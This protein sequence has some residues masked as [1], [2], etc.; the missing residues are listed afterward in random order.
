MARSHKIRWKK[1]DYITLG[2]AVANFNKHINEIK[3]LENELYLPDKIDY[4]SLKKDILTRSELKRKIKS[5]K[6]FQKETAKDLYQ[7]EAGEIMTQWE[8]QQLRNLSRV[9]SSRINKELKE[10][11]TPI[12]EGGFSRAQMGSFRYRELQ[13]QLRNLQ[14]IEKVAGYEFK[15]LKERLQNV[16]RKD[17]EFRKAQIYRENYIRE[18]E[19]YKNFENYEL[20]E[21]KLK[22]FKNP[23]D[24]YEFIS[25][26]ELTEDLTY[27]SD[28]V[29]SQ[30]EFNYFLE[31][32]EIL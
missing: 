13:S 27:Q 15:R 4:K 14:K 5:L 17:Y 30:D 2:K 22:S 7:T 20:L 31:E 26:N 25:K 19:K 29:Y 8:R 32:L 28:E 12:G 1:S 16:G 21:N 6:D 18:L 23:L 11:T 9:A 3:T 24:F 10:L